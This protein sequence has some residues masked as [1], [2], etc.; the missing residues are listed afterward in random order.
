MTLPI[1]LI[2]WIGLICL[3]LTEGCR[4]CLKRAIH[5]NC[6]IPQFSHIPPVL[7]RKSLPQMPIR[8]S[9]YSEKVIT[10]FWSDNSGGD[11]Y[12]EDG[13]EEADSAVVDNRDDSAMEPLKK[14]M[15]SGIKWYRNTL[16]PIMPPNCRFVPSCSNYAI[17]AITEFGALRGGVLTAWRL[18]R[19]NP[20]GPSGYDPPMWPPPGLE[21]VL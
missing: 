21:R 2:F 11:N 17:Q 20:L 15:I 16:S 12:N 5:V 6:N 7:S 10:M 19:C 1:I 9:K 8:T 14:F 13:E 18:L 3:T 4:L